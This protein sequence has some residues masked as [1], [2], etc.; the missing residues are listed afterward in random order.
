MGSVIPRS[1]EERE[2]SSSRSPAAAVLDDDDL[3][4]EILLRL[5]PQP[6]SLPRASLVCKRWRRLV[7]DPK[8]TRCFR[9]RHRRNTPL[10][11]CFVEKA[12]GL[13]FLPTMEAPN[14]VPPKRFSSLFDD[15]FNVVGCR[16]GLVLLS[17]ALRKQVVVWDPVTAYQHHIAVPVG[18][19]NRFTQG[20]V[21]LAPGDGHHF[22]VAM[23]VADGKDKQ[24]IRVLSCVYSSK[25][26]EWSDVVSM[27]I[28]S[29]SLPM[30]VL[31]DKPARL[32]GNS[33]YW[34]FS[35]RFVGFLEFDLERQNL[36]MI[37]VPVD[38][39]AKAKNWDFMV[40][41]AEGGGLGLL[42][43]SDFTAQL[44]KRTTGGDG[45][46]SWVLGRTIEPGELLSLNLVK[47][48]LQPHLLG[49]AD[50]NNV[51]FLR[52]ISGGL[53]II[54]LESLQFKKLSGRSPISWYH[55]FECVYAS[56]RPRSKKT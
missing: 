52:T 24:Y 17:D 36:T 39:Y 2:M 34:T 19:H 20:T 55:P 22:Q 40:I 5:P 28:P 18:F 23:A 30:D 27:P 16:H 38:V 14:C 10:L 32:V 53:F 48:M 41:Q 8:F 6:S 44:W 51:V 54:H 45:V 21:L 7:S 33:L 47:K 12:S 43:L 49:F 35:G 37:P 31:A 13:T 42:F 1:S 26:S 29:S 9:L 50:D 15:R 56:E 25:A 46:A 4:S 3:L 11:G